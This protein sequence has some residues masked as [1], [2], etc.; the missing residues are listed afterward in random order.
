MGGAE[1]NEQPG[2][3]ALM[4]QGSSKSSGYSRSTDTSTDTD[5]L[6]EMDHLSVGSDDTNQPHQISFMSM[7]STVHNHCLPQLLLNSVLLPRVSR[8]SNICTSTVA[9]SPKARD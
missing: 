1:E 6:T 5:E 2:G 4:D 3:Q 7:E 9:E 8:S